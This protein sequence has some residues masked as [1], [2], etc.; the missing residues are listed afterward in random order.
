M[1]LRVVVT[2]GQFQTCGQHG[3]Q[4]FWRGQAMVVAD[5]K[6][7]INPKAAVVEKFEAVLERDNVVLAR[8]QDAGVLFYR[9][10]SSPVFPGGAE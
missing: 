1:E 4:R 5:F 2:V 9:A 6:K 8:M 10:R 3:G 7:P